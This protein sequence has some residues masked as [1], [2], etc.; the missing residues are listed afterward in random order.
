M[1]KKDHS[2][3]A[4]ITYLSDRQVLNLYQNTPTTVDD[5]TIAPIAYL[6]DKQL[7]YLY[8]NAL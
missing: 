4:P 1:S 7:G 6:S 2:T 3:I 8:Q 5:S